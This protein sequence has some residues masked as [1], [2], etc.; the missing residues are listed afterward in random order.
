MFEEL[1]RWEN[2]GGV[3]VNR[4]SLYNQGLDDDPKYVEI[5]EGLKNKYGS[6]TLDPTTFEPVV[7][8][9][10]VVQ[11]RWIDPA[12]APLTVTNPD[13][14]KLPGV[15]ARAIKHSREVSEKEHIKGDRFERVNIFLTDLRREIGPVFEGEL[16]R[17]LLGVLCRKAGWYDIGIIN[18]G[19]VGMWGWYK[20]DS[21]GYINMRESY[22]KQWIAS[23]EAQLPVGGD[24]AEEIKKDLRSLDAMIFG[25]D[26]QIQ[27]CQQINTEAD[28]LMGRFE[29]LVET[30]QQQ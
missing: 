21:G 27:A 23:A 13:L 14:S 18:T 16:K 1:D 5:I 19:P 24:L 17:L 3:G 12:A 15:L 28:K 9:E 10:A 20:S 25:V 26:T 29:T 11:V 6:A 7:R 8:K 2:E 30:H 4:R 22:M